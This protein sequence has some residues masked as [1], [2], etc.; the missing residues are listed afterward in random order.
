MQVP[1]A[2]VQREPPV[3]RIG[4]GF[5]EDRGETLLGHNYRYVFLAYSKTILDCTVL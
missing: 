4:F 3:R 2:L 5:G 1:Q